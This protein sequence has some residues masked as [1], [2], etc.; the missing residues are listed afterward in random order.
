VLGDAP[1]LSKWIA[2]LLLAYVVL[3]PGE[4]VIPLKRNDW[5]GPIVTLIMP[6]SGPLLGVSSLIIVASVI[7]GLLVVPVIVVV[8]CSVIPFVIS[9]LR[10]QLNVPAGNVI[11]SPSRAEFSRVRTLAT[12]PLEW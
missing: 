12:D 7:V 6:A 4:K 2:P 9:K 11:V 8:P 5:L 10:D 3:L 1:L